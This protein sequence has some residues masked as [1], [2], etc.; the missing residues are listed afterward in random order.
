MVALGKYRPNP[1]TH[2]NA[3]AW[4]TFASKFTEAIRSTWKKKAAAPAQQ[5]AQGGKGGKKGGKEEAKAAPAKKK[6][7]PA[8]AAAE[9]ELDDLFADDPE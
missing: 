8:K 5:A 2:P 9:E 4:F 6:A 1:L 3:Y 7:A